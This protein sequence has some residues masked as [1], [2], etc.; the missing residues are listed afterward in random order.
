MRPETMF[1][2]ITGWFGHI[3]IRIAY[4]IIWI[5]ALIGGKTARAVLYEMYASGLNV[6][7]LKEPTP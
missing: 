2:K 7:V 3:P 4:R 6:P 1:E 5:T